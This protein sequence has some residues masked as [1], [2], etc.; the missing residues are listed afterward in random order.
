MLLPGLRPLTVRAA[1]RKGAEDACRRHCGLT[2]DGHPRTFTV[3]RLDPEP[4]AGPGP[5]P[6]GIRTSAEGGPC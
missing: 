6:A 2:D 5:A 4:A 1:D 3:D